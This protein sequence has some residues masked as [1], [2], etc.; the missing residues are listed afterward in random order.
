MEPLAKNYER[1]LKHSQE[2]GMPTEQYVKDV[3]SQL[4]KARGYLWN[5][6]EIWAG[7][8]SWLVWWINTFLP[9]GTFDIFMTR[10][11]GLGRLAGTQDKKG[12]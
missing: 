1:R 9:V 6:K 5:T 12:V 3:V 2:V 4:L 10:E 11:F 7:S 8:N